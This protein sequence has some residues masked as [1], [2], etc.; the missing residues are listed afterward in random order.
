MIK[1]HNGEHWLN[2][3]GLFN[4]EN[5]QPKKHPHYSTTGYIEFLIIAFRKL[6]LWKDIK[7]IVFIDCFYSEKIHSTHLPFMSKEP[8]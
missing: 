2:K 5:I 8:H 3:R 6:S 1:C 7:K 4:K